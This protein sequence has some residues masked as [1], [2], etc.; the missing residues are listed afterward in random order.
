M[1]DLETMN[2]ATPRWPCIPTSTPI[3]RSGIGFSENSIR[4]APSLYESMGVAWSAQLAE[5]A[6]ETSLA[7]ERHAGKHRVGAP[8]SLLQR[9]VDCRFVNQSESC[10]LTPTHY[11]RRGREPPVE[12][13]HHSRLYCIDN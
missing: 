1:Q 6:L 11:I 13:V 12:M 10:N 8:P 7:I 5:E 3:P 2:S 4:G 9:K